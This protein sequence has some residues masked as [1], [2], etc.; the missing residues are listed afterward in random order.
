MERPSIKNFMSCSRNFAIGTGLADE[1]IADIIEA[2]ESSGGT[3]SQA[4]LGNTVF[5]VCPVDDIEMREEIADTLSD[6]GE[7]LRYRVSPASIR[8]I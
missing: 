6:F 1:R 8:L 5:A 3:A 4:M 7:V 2:V